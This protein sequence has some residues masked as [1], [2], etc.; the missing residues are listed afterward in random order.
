[1][2][3]AVTVGLLSSLQ[4][5]AS[6]L[7]DNEFELFNQVSELKNFQL[8]KR[9][10]FRHEVLFS[11]RPEASFDSALIRTVLSKLQNDTNRS[12]VAFFNPKTRYLLISL[13][14]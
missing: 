1:M 7:V 6:P 8:E 14:G 13:R 3:V 4:E 12:Y 2:N 11:L 9:D 10:S 5:T